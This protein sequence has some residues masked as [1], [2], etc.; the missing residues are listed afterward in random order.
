MSLSFSSVAWSGLQQSFV[1]QT[2]GTRPH[3]TNQKLL[4]GFYLRREEVR[5]FIIFCKRRVTITSRSKNIRYI[6]TLD[7]N[8]ID[9]NKRKEASYMWKY[10]KWR[11]QEDR[12]RRWFLHAMCFRWC[13][14][15]EDWFGKS[16]GFLLFLFRCW[17]MFRLTI[18]QYL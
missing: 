17:G 7:S 8:S 3:K 16:A 14:I 11:K 1:L 4:K 10:V 6:F 18:V 5:H 15:L 12:E 9:L 13:A 2:N